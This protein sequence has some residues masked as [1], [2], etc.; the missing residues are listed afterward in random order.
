M[1]FFKS[2]DDLKK[3]P[4]FSKLREEI[5]EGKWALFLG[6]GASVG[7]KNGFGKHPPLASE[8]ST[9]LS[10]FLGV[11]NARNSLTLPMLAKLA[12][13]KDAPAFRALLESHYR[14]CSPGWQNL[15]ASFLWRNIYTSNIDDV[16]SAVYSPKKSPIQRAN[17][18]DFTD[19]IPVSISP[20]TLS[21][22][23]LHGMI[24][25]AKGPL[26]FSPNEYAE[27]AKDNW[28][29]FHSF[30]KD[31][32]DGRMIYIGS[33]LQEP[34]FDF[35]ISNRREYQEP[36]FPSLLV[37]PSIESADANYFETLGI[38]CVKTGG[39][40]FIQWLDNLTSGRPATPKRLS[41][42][43]T[44]GRMTPF[45]KSALISF[46]SCFSEL[47]KELPTA[48]A[49]SYE[50]FFSGGNLSIAD[51]E[52][53][54]DCLFTHTETA[55]K[56]AKDF[57]S[58]S[59]AGSAA[60]LLHGAAG[61]GKSTALRRIS[62][63]LAEN[64]K[65]IFWHNG[66]KWP[67]GTDHLNRVLPGK[68]VLVVDNVNHFD[69]QVLRFLE[70]AER[71]N[72]S[73]LLVAATRDRYEPRVS[74]SLKGAVSKPSHFQAIECNWLNDEDV[75]R[76]SKHLVQKE[77]LGPRLRDKKM[78]E[79][80]EF[81][82]FHASKILLAAMLDAFLGK[83]HEETVRS[84]FDEMSDFGKSIYRQV[85]LTESRGELIDLGIASRA[86]REP[87][88]KI[89]RRVKG[90]D[91]SED[92][93]EL[94]SIINCEEKGNQRLLRTRHRIIAEYVVKNLMTGSDCYHV[95]RG[96]MK[97]ITAFCSQESTRNRDAPYRLSKALM[98]Q[99][100][101]TEELKIEKELVNEL[102]NELEAG[103][104]WNYHF[105]L[106]RATFELHSTRRFSAAWDYCQKALELEG[107]S[108]LPK[109]TLA[110]ICFHRAASQSKFDH[111]ADDLKTGS[112]I[113]HNLF[114]AEVTEPLLF[115]VAIRGYFHVGRTFR[116]I[117]EFQSEIKKWI[118][119][120]KVATASQKMISFRTTASELLNKTLLQELGG[121]EID[122]EPLDKYQF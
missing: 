12:Q 27:A 72:R 64:T 62:Y 13:K 47:P 41:S 48:F 73:V 78:E 81:F 44:E 40:E 77:R 59:N 16:L 74:I 115:A 30:S 121:I 66:E 46:S 21:I 105:W 89:W 95:V 85:A 70:S 82:T 114:D 43:I 45:E 15:L 87:P 50:D 26:I 104:S 3:D 6:A 84:E 98:D 8:L 34:D 56:A 71:L 61:G 52:A 2:A 29:A 110:N 11:E 88:T 90:S 49:N 92:R 25:K 42:A 57:L 106:Q 83:G 31:Q 100:W 14:N 103:W 17:I 117:G 109:L 54:N 122:I 18:R 33:R 86:M 23:H 58:Q 67:L 69:R 53:R 55:I 79:I 96:T 36:L 113:I 101:L 75:S 32:L 5:E 24:G 118:E 35:Y 108:P 63:D 39:K 20:S 7:A 60:I 91:S 107:R 112:D 68:F 111:A 51:L 65:T 38:H 102:F 116:K 9:I 10:E 1:A 97:A 80:Q 99:R 4:L 76:L 22:V 28:Y 119:W 37:D 93:H 120:S 19:R 94:R